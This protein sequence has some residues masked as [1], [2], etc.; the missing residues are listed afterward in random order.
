MDHQLIPVSSNKGGR[1]RA[2]FPLDRIREL[3]ALGLTQEQAANRLGYSGKTLGDAMQVDPALRDAW[4]VSKATAIAKIADTLYQKAASGDTGAMIF[5]LR[6]QAG[7][8]AAKSDTNVR[9][10]VTSTGPT[11]DGHIED[12]AADHARLLACVD[13]DLDT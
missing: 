12:M 8:T 3:A 11:I 13:D 2:F 6:C 10:S 7:W 4:R 9:V 5:W 1:P